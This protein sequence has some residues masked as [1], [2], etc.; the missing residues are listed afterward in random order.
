V[1][2][3]KPP[4]AGVA[5]PE[6]VLKYLARYTHRVA[7]SNRRLLMLQDGQVKL[8]YKDYAAGGCEKILTLSATEFLRRFL[9]HV[10]PSGF[11]K[12]RH[13]GLLA[14]RRREEK[15]TICRRLL[16]VIA[17]AAVISTVLGGQ[18]D[19]CPACGGTIWVVVGHTARPTI[20]EVCALPLTVDTS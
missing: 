14:N 2:Y 8:Q 16:L 7:L 19:A 20:A 18:P 9:Q 15:L 5:Q 10:L 1:V 17:T 6:V 12:V 3:S 4:F 13:Y 11:V